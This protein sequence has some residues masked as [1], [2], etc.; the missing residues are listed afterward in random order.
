MVAPALNFRFVTG[1]VANFIDKP[2]IQR[3]I[4]RAQRDPKIIN[5]QG[6]MVRRSARSSIR[7]VQKQSTV[8][9]PGEAPRSHKKKEYNLRTIRYEWDQSSV[10]TIVG[11][12]GFGATAGDVPSALEKGGTVTKI[13]RTYQGRS[14]KAMSA[15]QKAAF[16]R[17][18]KAGEIASRKQSVIGTTQ[19]TIKIAARPF[20]F[21]A[22][23][24]EAPKFAGMWEDSIK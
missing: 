19:A 1:N 14:R 12:I 15:K 22:L 5:R 18:V 7:Q 17:K 3:A 21:P 6:G 24:K 20:M 23:R 10:G 9:K 11:P 8:S 13:R 4:R 2:A 16:K